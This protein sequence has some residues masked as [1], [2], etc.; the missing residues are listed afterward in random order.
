MTPWRSSARAAAIDHSRDMI[1][2]ATEANRQAVEEGR[3][4]ILEADAGSLPFADETFSC[5]VMTGVFNFFSDPLTPL[6]EIHRVLAQGGRLVV[7]TSGKELRN[8]PAAPEPVASRIFFH[9]NKE[10]QALAE[11]AG[12]AP[13]KVFSPDLSK[14]AAEV[15]VPEEHVG[16]FEGTGGQLLVAWK[17]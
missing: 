6:R 8:T 16:L 13:V 2:V 11:D 12:F 14:Y 15:G 7:F 17:N 3:L 1:G 4:E 9:E 10:L 5:A